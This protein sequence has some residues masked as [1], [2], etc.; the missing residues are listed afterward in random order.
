MSTE[1]V[2]KPIYEQKCP[3]CGAPLVFNPTLGKMECQWCGTITEVEQRDEEQP[4]SGHEE[5]DRALAEMEPLPIY[6]CISC[7]AE[8]IA[9]P[10]SGA[11]TCPYCKNHIVLTQQ[12]SGTIKPDGIIPFKFSADKLPKMLKTFYSDKKLLPRNFFSTVSVGPVTG[13]Y[14]P[15]WLFD[16]TAAGDVT[17]QGD[18][19]GN[20]YRQG[21]YILTDV[22]HYRLLRNV[23][24]GFAA[25]P[26]DASKKMADAVMESAQ[27]YNFDELVPFDMKYL[28]G[29]VADRFD[30]SSKESGKRNTQLVKKTADAET[31]RRTTE[32][33]ENVKTEA[34]DLKTTVETGRYVLLP[35]Y[36]FNLN[37]GGKEYPFVVNG[38]TGKIV[39]RLPESRDVENQW[40]L[41]RF[42][43]GF[44]TAAAI[45]CALFVR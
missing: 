3:A 26:V 29:F 45:I 35:V 44:A 40:I 1:A 39:G 13:I 41:R 14:V 30:V 43:I 37:Y 18:K 9:L 33:F 24:M 19:Y 12:F 36:S 2:K 31:I 25:L 38:Q 34:N 7:G 17:Y 20:S 32:G 28:A 6:N 8:V 4:A 22:S 11:L 10:E 15:F 23:S 16:S 5:K 27:P 21:D 42:A